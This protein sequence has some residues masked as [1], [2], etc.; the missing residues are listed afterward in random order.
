MS[1][2]KEPSDETKLFKLGLRSGHKIVLAKSMARSEETS[3]HSVDV[4]EEASSADCVIQAVLGNKLGDYQIDPNHTC[5]DIDSGVLDPCL[6]KE[7][8]S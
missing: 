2:G 8:A 3:E 4:K 7:Q 5:N 6:Y 1:L